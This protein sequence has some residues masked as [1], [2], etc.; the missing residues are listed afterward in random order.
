M[1]NI[2]LKKTPVYVKKTKKHK[3]TIAILLPLRRIEN[4]HPLHTG[5]SCKSCRSRRLRSPGGTLSQLCRRPDDDDNGA[6]T[7][8]LL[9]D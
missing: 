9:F 3:L 4:R 6:K 5:P 7:S 1:E 8:L 2:R